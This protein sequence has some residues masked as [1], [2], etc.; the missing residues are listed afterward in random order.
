MTKPFRNL[1]E[2]IKIGSLE[3]KNR[4]VMNAMHLGFEEDGYLSDKTIDFYEE[5][6]KGGVGLI[7]AGGFKIE[8][9]G[10]GKTFLSIS[11]D[12]F[13][14]GLSRLVST[15]KNGGAAIFSQL[16]HAGRYVH[17]GEIGEKAVSASP[18]KCRLTGETPRPLSIKEIKGIV[19]SYSA[20]ALRAKKA[21]FDGIEV[22]AS[23]GYLIAQFLSPLTN[24]R[25]DEYGGDAEKRMRFGLEIAAA[26]RSAVDGEFPVIFRISGND[27]MD[28]GNT[29]EEAAVFARKLEAL[30]IDAINVQSGWHEARVPTVQNI[31]PPGA[32]AYLAAGIKQSVACPVMTCNKL[33][34][35]YL[36]ESV[37]ADGLADMIGLA[38]SFLAD[39]YLPLKVREG[40]PQDIVRCI[41]CNQGCLDMVFT[42]RPVTC[43]VNPFVGKESE[44]KVVPSKKKKRVLVAGGGPAGMYAARIAAMRGHDV[45]LYEKADNLGGQINLATALPHKEEFA[46]LVED[47]ESQLK[48]NGVAVKA[49]VEVTPE[50]VERLGP[51]AVVIATGAGP[52]DYSIP[53]AERE[54]VISAIDLIRSKGDIGRRVVVVGGG[55]LGCEVALYAAGKGVVSDRTLA[56]LLKMRAET[57]EALSTLAGRSPREVTLITRRDMLGPDIGQTTRWIFLQELARLKVRTVTRGSDIEIVDEGVRFRRGNEQ[58]TIEADTVIVSPGMAANQ[59]LYETLG[60]RVSEIYLIGDSKDPRKA[61]DAVREGAEVGLKL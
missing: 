16:F 22:L 53:G 28:G 37:L 5:R 21:G 61:L 43:M 59:E 15:V 9:I 42:R 7:I 50:E 54:N 52:R 55:S 20:A 38:R 29:N 34:N 60:N 31:V 44:W 3:I 39:P 57:P 49:G 35:P 41:H 1:F 36:A 56:F 4:Y 17:S 19:T 40:R 8:N 18:V 51:D 2:P 46:M 48:A 45:H 33:G 25:E 47:M 26:V 58:M 11:D 13:L 27:F 30:G 6:A 24:R 32:F 23:T 12:S 14:P 10:G